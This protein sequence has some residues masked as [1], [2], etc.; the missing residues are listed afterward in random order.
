VKRIAFFCAAAE[1]TARSVKKLTLLDG[2]TSA[3]RRAFLCSGL[4]RAQFA[5][6]RSLG[7]E[8]HFLFPDAVAPHDSVRRNSSARDATKIPR[9]E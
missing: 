2:S 6:D 7:K 5:I 4:A 8:E 1:S 9:R 3:V